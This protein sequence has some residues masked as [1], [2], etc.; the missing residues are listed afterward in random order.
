MALWFYAFTHCCPICKSPSALW[1]LLTWLWPAANTRSPAEVI[2]EIKRI[3]REWA[4]CQLTREKKKHFSIGLCQ[5]VSDC[6]DSVLW[7]MPADQTW[8]L[9]PLLCLCHVSHGLSFAQVQSPQGF[10]SGLL[11]HVYFYTKRFPRVSVPAVV[12]GALAQKSFSCLYLH[13]DQGHWL[14]FKH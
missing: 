13:K 2:E 6:R 9:S 7:Q 12:S 4:Q 11:L 3:A 8:P 14:V 5:F 1:E 10:G